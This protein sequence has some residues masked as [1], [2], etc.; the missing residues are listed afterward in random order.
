MSWTFEEVDGKLKDIMK[1]IFD[2]AKENAEKYGVPD[3]YVAGANITAFKKVADAMIEL[4]L[5]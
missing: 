4:G 2:Q 1:D 3:N 5:V